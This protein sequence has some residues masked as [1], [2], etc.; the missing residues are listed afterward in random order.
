METD[1]PLAGK[2]IAV[3]RRAEEAT[4]SAALLEAAG[5]IPVLLPAI[6]LRPLYDA[7]LRTALS[8]TGRQDWL[9]F[10]SVPAVDRFIQ[11]CEEWGIAP[12]PVPR[13]A[14][15]GP[16]T[17]QRL[18]ERTDAEP[19]LPP[20]FR[21]AIL[22]ETLPIESGARVL[23]FGARE[24]DPL[25]AGNLRQRGAQVVEVALYETI[26]VL[27]SDDLARELAQGLDAVTFASPSAVRPFVALAGVDALETPVVACIGDTTAAAARA[28]GVMV[29]VVSSRHTFADLVQSI[30]E[31]Y[32]ERAGG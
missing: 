13:F 11:V 22:G 14:A 28:L 2:R 24:G 30:S 19:W 4:E 27:S 18:R 21:G 29:E 23:V 9:V 32:A 12:L 10:A 6:S 16:K 1:L 20:R 17:A 25:L 5:A 3:T 26:P 8:E 31:Y 15:V 7:H